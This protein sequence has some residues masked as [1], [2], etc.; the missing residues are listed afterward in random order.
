MHDG[1]PK[2][3]GSVDTKV[4]VN[5]ELWVYNSSLRKAARC[6]EWHN[7]NPGEPCR[8][9]KAAIVKAP[10][11]FNSPCRMKKPFDPPFAIRLSVSYDGELAFEC[12]ATCYLLSEQQRSNLETWNPEV[13]GGEE[14]LDKHQQEVTI[15]TPAAGVPGDGGNA[16]CTRDLEFTE[17][18]FRQPTRMSK[19]YILFTLQCTEQ[20]SLWLIYTLPTVVISRTADQYNKALLVLQNIQPM[21]G[22]SLRGQANAAANAA[23]A[24]WAAVKALKRS[25]P[26]T[27]EE[28]GAGLYYSPSVCE[29]YIYAKYKAVGFT[30]LLLPD[31]VAFLQLMAGF[32]SVPGNP[33]IVARQQPALSEEQWEGFAKWFENHLL[34]GLKNVSHLWE[35]VHPCAISAFTTTREMAEQKLLQ[36]PVGTFCV[37]PRVQFQSPL[38]WV[39]SYR[40][41]S[42]IEHNLLSEEHLRTHSLEVWV[43]DLNHLLYCMDISTNRLRS[44]EEIFLHGY[45]R[46]THQQEGVAQ[47]SPVSAPP[48]G[49]GSFG[50]LRSAFSRPESA[51]PE[52]QSR[53]L[54]LNPRSWSSR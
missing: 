45:T 28:D 42:G 35:Q 17:L 22:R 1:D 18:V 40:S 4:D 16:V 29:D 32:S 44:K 33:S 31:E 19:R 11:A 2:A 27:S 3:H 41:N 5:Q 12:R 46:H 21:D 38:A 49:G 13:H 53:W 15:R 8:A 14:N 47:P 6:D 54:A 34:L 48:R 30:R 37:R 52:H 7:P 51:N 25:S 26:H 39:I 36:A 43:R 50:L 23:A 24:T 20:L 10:A 9:L